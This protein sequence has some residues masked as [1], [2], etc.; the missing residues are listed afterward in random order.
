MPNEHKGGHRGWSC[1]KGWG[2]RSFNPQARTTCPEQRETLFCPKIDHG[3]TLQKKKK[4][5]RLKIY[6]S[7]SFLSF[8]SYFFFLFFF[9]EEKNSR[10][11]V[12]ARIN[13]IKCYVEL[14]T[15]ITLSFSL[16]RSK[17]ISYIY[18]FFII[19]NFLSLDILSS[20]K[21]KRK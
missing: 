1:W 19:I 16:S 14:G 11:K 21:M 5:A 7:F 10:E 12:P 18:I 8:L 6:L 13:V 20:R 9:L 17:N 3:I 15:F 4:K 2:W